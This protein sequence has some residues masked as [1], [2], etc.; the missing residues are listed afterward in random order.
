MEPVPIYSPF[1]DCLFP[2]SSPTQCVTNSFIVVHLR[3]ENA[4]SAQLQFTF[5]L[6]QVSSEC[7]R[8]IVF[9]FTGTIFI[10][11]VHFSIGLLSFFPPSSLYWLLLKNLLLFGTLNVGCGRLLELCCET[12]ALSK[13]SETCFSTLFTGYWLHDSKFY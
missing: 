1:R 3:V 11:F 13:N 5:T 7:L 2:T 8:A 10:S 9:S 12:G 6:S 4:V